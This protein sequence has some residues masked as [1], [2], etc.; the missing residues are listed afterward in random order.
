MILC[1]KPGAIDGTRNVPYSC[2][3]NEEL[4]PKKIKLRGCISC[5]QNKD[6]TFPEVTWSFPKFPQEAAADNAGIDSWVVPFIILLL[7]LLVGIGIAAALIVYKHRSANN[8]QN[9][10]TTNLRFNQ[11]CS[12]IIESGNSQTLSPP[13][14][15]SSRSQEENPPS[16]LPPPPPFKSYLVL[17]S[18]W[19]HDEQE[20]LITELQKAIKK[21]KPPNTASLP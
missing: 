15:Q 2:F 13:L 20:T 18:R 3:T 14:N 9:L 1:L 21:L 5:G 6:K 10:R 16:T 7:G 11:G 12:R 8:E 4:I 17:P 19:L